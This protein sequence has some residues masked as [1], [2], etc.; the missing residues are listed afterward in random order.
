MRRSIVGLALLV[1]AFV[2]A[3]GP[4]ATRPLHD[5]GVVVGKDAAGDVHAAGLTRVER[6]AID[7]VSVKA[8]GTADLGV[9][10]TATFRGN[11]E[12]AIGRGGLA[13]AAAMLVLQ[14][15]SSAAAS[16]GVLSDG[17]GKIGRVVRHTKSTDVGAYRQGNRLTFVVG[18]PGYDH[19]KSVEVRT[20]IEPKSLRALSAASDGPPIMVPR[21]WDRYI[22]LR[23]VDLSAVIADPGNLSCPELDE[24][25]L[26]ID[27]DLDDPYFAAN[28]PSSTVQ[29]LYKF[30]ATVKAPRDSTCAPGGTSTPPTLGATFAWHAFSSNEVAGVGQF[31]GPATTF[32]AIRVVLPGNFAITNHLC[33]SQLPNATISG[34]SID[35]GGGTLQTGQSFTLNLQTAPNPPT[36]IGG[37]LYG[38]AGGTFL[39]PFPITGP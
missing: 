30:R 12:K 6:D 2:S 19:V 4:A 25:L 18:G 28:V 8:V 21:I 35:C 1:V 27:Q 3:V 13:N 23:P 36:G 10:V 31:T 32:Q 14:P 20:L 17:P 9:V 33:P 7:I 24:L 34:N 22:S 15:D 5:T 38:E 11:F 16:A 29:A 26:S 39:G 37:Q